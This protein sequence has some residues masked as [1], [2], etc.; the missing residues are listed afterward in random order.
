[1]AVDEREARERDSS[2]P[3]GDE[4]DSSIAPERA[5]PEEMSEH[6]MESEHRGRYL[7]AAELADGLEVIDAGCG[8]GYGSE[9]LAAAGASR[10]V[11]VDISTEAIEYARAASSHASNEF[12]LGS[13][14][15][16]PFAD[17]S[18]DLAVC[19]EVIE[20]VEEQPR[21]I[22][23]LRRVLKSGGLLAISSPNRDV[24]P[25]G[26]PHHLHEFVPDELATAL[27]DE[28]A[29]VHLYRQSPWLAAA[30][31][32]DDESRS[33]GIDAAMQ[34][35]VVK[36]AAVEPGA[37][38]YTVALASDGPLPEADAIALLGKPFEL[39]W[40]QE[41][42]A[43]MKEQLD[44]ARANGERLSTELLR[45]KEELDGA[46]REAATLR[47]T[48]AT[49]RES[50]SRSAHR[51]LEVEAILADSQARVAALEEAYTAHSGQL[52]N[53]QE[54][55]DRA[56]RVQAAMKAS[57]SWRLTAPLRLLKRRR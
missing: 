29:N 7:W 42:L 56:D 20:H 4:R 9:I 37:E 2:P 30:I 34:P 39:R 19:F 13:L 46:A 5:A 38:M 53:L 23:E 8:T 57:I 32:D 43:G 41:Q 26:N 3:L 35:K 52:A 28:F 10:V 16:L 1:V 45:L 55:L 44:A 18:F 24:Y 31:F 14:H 27:G 22:A 15:E 21:A 54:R 25:P 12:Q 17:A 11:G 50:E 6:L 36:L 47:Q 40:W 51:V 49:A 48:T 33:T